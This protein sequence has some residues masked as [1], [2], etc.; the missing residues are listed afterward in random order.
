MS[1]RLL[2]LKL[3]ASL[4][5]LICGGCNLPPLPLAPT[6]QPK[7]AEAQTVNL[8][9]TVDG[10]GKVTV[11][12]DSKVT[13]GGDATITAKPASAA[14]EAACECGCEKAGCTCSRVRQN[15]G[16]LTPPSV[17]PR[18]LTSAATKP[19]VELLTDF[20]DGQCGA[21]DLA[22]LDWKTNGQAWPFTVVKVRGNKLGG[23]SPTFRFANGRV[24]RPQFYSTGDLPREFSQGK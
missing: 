24:W 4:A 17:A 1:T 2:I 16:L 21:C 20:E 3:A 23:T 11:G 5:A 7:P 9:I 13:V 10:E 18:T 19:I 8:K 22:W 15:A 12:G 6:P 14:T